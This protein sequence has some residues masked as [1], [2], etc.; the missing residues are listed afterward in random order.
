MRS[1][2]LKALAIHTADEA[3]PSDG[4]D[5]SFGWGLLNTKKAAEVISGDGSGGHQI[6]EASLNNGGTYQVQITPIIGSGNK[7]KATLVWTD[8]PGTPPPPSVDTPDLML[9]NDLD[10]RIIGSDT[11]SLPWTLN[12][13]NPA[14]AAT[15][16]DNTRDNVEQIFFEPIKTETYTVQVIHKGTL[17]NESPQDFSLILSYQPAQAPYRFPWL[18]FLPAIFGNRQ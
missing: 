3:G 16:G 9:V 6:K 5:Y 12:P 18:M 2:T 13:A 14:T 17:K 7:I 11:T 15:K 10:L 8:P 4:P 1:A